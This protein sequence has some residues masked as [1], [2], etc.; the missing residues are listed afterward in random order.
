MDNHIGNEG[1]KAIGE[2]LKTNTSLTEIYLENTNS[3]SHF[4]YK[5]IYLLVKLFVGD[6][7]GDE[8]AK[9]LGEGLKTNTTLTQIN[10][11]C[12]SNNYYNIIYYLLTFH[13]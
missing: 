3:D 5:M 8:G 10:L 9:A 4:F 7:I 13:S 2:G 1:G 12:D 6:G 11:N